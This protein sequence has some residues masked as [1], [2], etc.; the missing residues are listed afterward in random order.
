M[1]KIEVPLMSCLVASSM[2]LDISVYQSAAANW[3]VHDQ[4]NSVTS[5]GA[6]PATKAVTSFGRMSSQLSVWRST[7]MPVA[8]SNSAAMFDPCG[9]GSSTVID[10]ANAGVA[11]A[12]PAA[13]KVDRRSLR[14]SLFSCWPLGSLLKRAVF[15]R[16]G[17]DRGG[18]AL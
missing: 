18:K 16:H 8:F 9:D 7:W 3:P 15:G 17:L 12:S 10:S 2:A 5:A 1:L 14:M 11:A 13:M 6:V 4:S